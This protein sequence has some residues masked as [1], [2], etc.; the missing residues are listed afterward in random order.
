MIEVGDRVRTYDGTEGSVSDVQ[1]L[2]CQLR[3]PH[4]ECGLF[5]R[6]DDRRWVNVEYLE[7][8]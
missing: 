3:H 8:L 6:V 1:C 4:E 7:K 2:D 5:A